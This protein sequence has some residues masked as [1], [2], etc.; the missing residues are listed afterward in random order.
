MDIYIYIYIYIYISIIQKQ[1]SKTKQ[2]SSPLPELT[3]RTC[4]RDVR[5]AT[6]GHWRTRQRV[7]SRRDRAI[8]TGATAAGLAEVHGGLGLVDE[9]TKEIAN[10]ADVNQLY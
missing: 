5:I 1:N 8:C 10:G 6:H 9:S 7:G 2:T 3:T 4:Q